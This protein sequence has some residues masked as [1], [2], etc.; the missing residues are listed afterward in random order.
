MIALFVGVLLCWPIALSGAIFVFADT[1][2]YFYAGAKIWTLLQEI[3]AS[4]Q[5]T[6][7][8]TGPEGA[9]STSL[10]V[11]AQ[12]DNAV[13]RSF[14][15]SVMVFSLDALTGLTSVSVVQGAL[16]TMMVLPLISPAAMERPSVLVLGGILVV[17][18]SGLAFYSVFLM[19]DIFA[20]FPIL[21][22]AS[23]IRGFDALS[24]L[25][26]V[27]L[28]ALAAFAVTTHYGYPLLMAGLVVIVLFWRLVSR[29]LTLAC[30]A[31]AIIPVLFSPVANL[32]AS[33][34]VLETPSAAP[35]RLPILLA[36]SLADGPA[37]WYLQDACPE[38]DLAFCEAFS[39]NIPTNITELL[40]E[41]DGINSLTPE[42]L[43]RI[44]NEE[45]TILLRA[46]R[47]Y[48]IAQ[49]KS[50]L[51]NAVRQLSLVGLIM[52]T[53]K[54]LDVDYRP[55]AAKDDSGE[56]LLILG[57]QIIPVFTLLSALA[58]AGL[59]VSRQLTRG[60]IEILMV[61]LIGYAIN[62]VVFGGL[63]APDPRYQGRIAWLLPLLVV[64]FVAGRARLRSPDPEPDA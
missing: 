9:T 63:S 3:I 40:W 64:L 50:L 51:G 22:A 39:G 52:R 55:I 32:T 47:A 23:L 62:A 34:V 33:T 46:F 4:L 53:A 6:A 20:A 54:D 17:L 31:A 16:T 24:R 18:F 1:P 14:I 37:L 36:R 8:A 19:P 21:F 7:I 13:G 48:P 26:Q 12:G 49:T 2:S 44:R 60:Q 57:N 25:Q 58:L 56:R 38:A 30:I 10:A 41:D 29:R 61:V 27:M 59:F 11:G 15:Y 42:M 43:Q 28:V 45:M 5:Q 35:M